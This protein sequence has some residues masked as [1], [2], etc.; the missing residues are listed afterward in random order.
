MLTTLALTALLS[1]QAAPE[2][3]Q[4]PR[5][6]STLTFA[7]TRPSVLIQRIATK[8]M[9]NDGT[10]VEMTSTIVRCE[11]SKARSF[12]SALETANAGNL[13]L[14]A[15]FSSAV[16]TSTYNVMPSGSGSLARGSN[17]LRVTGRDNV[18]VDAHNKTYGAMTNL[19]EI[20]SALSAR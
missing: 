1:I 6:A 4:A 12:L 15:D 18:S 13:S 16:L 2:A 17:S 7:T 11:E 9:E 20:R 14:R 19:A 8:C 5:P 10:V 3:A